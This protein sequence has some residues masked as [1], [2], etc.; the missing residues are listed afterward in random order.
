MRK[1]E[2]GVSNLELSGFVR[3]KLVMDNIIR[4]FIGQQEIVLDPK[5]FERKHTEFCY[6]SIL[7]K[8]VL[9]KYQ[10]KNPDLQGTVGLLEVSLAELN[11]RPD[12][13]KGNYS[14]SFSICRKIPPKE[15]VRMYSHLAGRSNIPIN[16]EKYDPMYQVELTGEGK[17][18]RVH[19]PILMP[20]AG[21]LGG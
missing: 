3:K 13:K 5:T 15:Y 7:T 14:I 20:H 8:E 12:V 19:D 16:Y 17:A 2:S 6:L 18:V 21:H 11:G 9:V 4:N 10:G 1:P